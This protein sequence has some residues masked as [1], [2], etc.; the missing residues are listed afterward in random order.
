M[1]L[2]YRS[3]LDFSQ[4]KDKTARY[5]NE[6]AENDALNSEKEII[7]ET[8]VFFKKIRDVEKQELIE[9]PKEKP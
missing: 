8:G 2:H 3:L 7:R 4:G 5:L 1:A 6:R 9:N